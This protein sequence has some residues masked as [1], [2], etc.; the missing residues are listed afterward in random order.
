[1]EARRSV[2]DQLQP[3]WRETVRALSG[4][5]VD[6]HYSRGWTQDVPLAQALLEARSRDQAKGLTHTG[7]HR[8]DVLVRI[9]GRPAREVL[10]RGQQKLAA[11]AMTLAQ[12]RLLRERSGM[13]PTLL[14]DDPAAELDETH[15]QRFIEQVGQLKCQLVLT[16]LHPHFDLFGRA[17]RV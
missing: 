2:L 9:G 13:S 15:L 4:L 17:E 11:I 10:S 6:L 5:E 1:G 12:I 8:A 7:P 14:L 16:S 3:V